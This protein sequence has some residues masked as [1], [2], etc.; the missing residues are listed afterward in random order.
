[1]TEKILKA[2]KE[3]REKTKKRNFTQTFDLIVNLKEIDLKKSE[4]KF[5]EDLILPHG[6]GK[7]TKIVIFSDIIK[8]EDVNFPVL[9][10][11]EIEILAK[12]KRE[13]KKLARKTDFFLAEPKLMPL[14]GKMLGQFLAPRGKMPKIITDDVKK[15]I[16]DYKKA[17]RIK[18][19]DSP[20]IQ[21]PVGNE[22]MEDEK[23]AE[24]IKTV[25]EFLKTK[26]P[27]GEKNIAE[28]FIKLTMS[29]PVKVE[30]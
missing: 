16:E 22:K 1:M 10:G 8:E 18:I 30:V 7:E 12:N 26:L 4:N 25:I 15:I 20:V 6:K 14:I 17:I 27:K 5:T 9:K 28:V 11:S 24:N 13:A 29:K 23:V 2:I 3:L 21:C 19:K